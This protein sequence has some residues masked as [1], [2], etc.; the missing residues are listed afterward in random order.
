MTMI[1]IVYIGP[2][3][4]TLHMTLTKLLVIKSNIL[5]SPLDF[6][7]LVMVGVLKV[8]LMLLL[9]SRRTMILNN[10]E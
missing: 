2:C 4:W 7:V 1:I 8:V 9:R 5:L 3:M 6:L 10:L